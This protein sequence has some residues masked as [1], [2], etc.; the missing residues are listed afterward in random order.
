MRDLTPAVVAIDPGNS[1]GIAVLTASPAPRLV[2]HDLFNFSK[3]R[4]GQATTPTE[5]LARVVTQAIDLGALVLA[6]VIEDQYVAKNASSAIALARCAGRWAEAC[7]EQIHRR[8]AAIPVE[9]IAASHWQRME[10]HGATRGRRPK[11]ADLKRASRDVVEQA[12]GVRIPIDAA[13]AVLLGRYF[14]TRSWPQL[15]GA[16]S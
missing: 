9:F 11:R 15:R 6:G 13:D 1:S 14:A 2:L 5:H 7:A 16:V 12:F 8:D 3:P 4:R 10:I